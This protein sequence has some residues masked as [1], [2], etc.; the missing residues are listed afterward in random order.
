MHRAVRLGQRFTAA[1]TERRG[2]LLSSASKPEQEKIGFI[3]S[4][5]TMA[6][7]ATTRWIE[8][9]LTL[10]PQVRTNDPAYLHGAEYRTTWLAPA[11]KASD[12]PQGGACL[13][14]PAGE[15]SYLLIMASGPG[16]HPHIMRKRERKLCTVFQRASGLVASGTGVACNCGDFD[17]R[18]PARCCWCH[19]RSGAAIQEPWRWANSPM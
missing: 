14:A 11:A 8:D 7:R 10:N 6:T 9:A 5:S 4:R 18:W 2:L 19:E 17:N 16:R 12:R 15:H 1:G 13:I 3:R